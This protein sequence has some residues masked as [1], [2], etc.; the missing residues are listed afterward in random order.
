MISAESNHFLLHSC[1]QNIQAHEGKLADTWTTDKNPHKQWVNQSPCH[2]A[3]RPFWWL[4]CLTCENTT[5]LSKVVKNLVKP[6]WQDG[7]FFCL[8]VSSLQGCEKLSDP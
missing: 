5:G 7:G 1:G 3:F 6:R 2:R 8:F 4:C